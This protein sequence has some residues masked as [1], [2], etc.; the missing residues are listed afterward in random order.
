[1]LIFI[2]QQLEKVNLS[3]ITVGNTVIEAKPVVRNLG[4]WFDRH[5]FR[6]M[7]THISKLSCLAF[8]H[9][10]NISR[11]RRFLSQ[12]DH[13]T[14]EALVHVFVTSRMDYCNSLLYIYQ[15][16]I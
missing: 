16:L 6:C 10:H 2:K 12:L 1:M 14:T 7:S 15:P 13:S 8:C 3:S 9:L 11:I 5:A 4:S